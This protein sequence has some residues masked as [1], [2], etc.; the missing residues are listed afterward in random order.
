[1]CAASLPPPQS[2]LPLAMKTTAAANEQAAAM[3]PQNIRTLISFLLFVHFFSLAV[4]L[5]LN[6][7]S[8]DLSQ[9]LRRMPGMYLQALFMDIDFDH[10]QP[11]QKRRFPM[12]EGALMERDNP[13][14][15]PR[16]R[17]GRYHLTQG[18]A[19]DCPF[20]VE[21]EIP[22]ADFL[23][24]EGSGYEGDRKIVTIP[25][26][27]I[28]PKQRYL[29]Y[30]TLA[31]EAARLNGQEEV[32]AVLLGG[33]GGGI[34]HEHG[35]PK[36]VPCRVRVWRLSQLT[37]EQASHADESIRDPWNKRPPAPDINLEGVIFF[38]KDGQVQFSRTLPANEVAPPPGAAPP[39][40]SDTGVSPPGV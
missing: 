23:R 9:K 29:R 12:P 32:D 28:G 20:F 26:Q 27:D 24:N 21:V 3:P 17:R 14:D 38:D 18:E 25:P 36:N 11:F 6:N 33:I 39:G 10:G 4:V 30:H 2:G 22:D 19:Y 13:R 31:W 5:V 1:M 7:S 34:L 35:V 40:S 16:G 15:M 37:T 8:T